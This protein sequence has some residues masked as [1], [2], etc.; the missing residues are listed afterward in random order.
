MQILIATVWNILYSTRIK[1]Q[2]SSPDDIMVNDLSSDIL[3]SC[4]VLKQ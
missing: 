1:W 2:T 4:S 3:H